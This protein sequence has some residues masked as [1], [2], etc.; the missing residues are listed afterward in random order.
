MTHIYICKV[1]I[2]GSPFAVLTEEE[3]KQWVLE[4]P[5]MNYYDTVEIKSIKQD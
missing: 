1:Q 5:Q 2:L 3:A 4:D